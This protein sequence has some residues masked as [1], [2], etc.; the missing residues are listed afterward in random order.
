MVLFPLATGLPIKSLIAGQTVISKNEMAYYAAI[1][2]DQRRSNDAN[3]WPVLTGFIF[4][5]LPIAVN[6]V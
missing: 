1:G 2:K 5:H 3:F 6:S 4:F